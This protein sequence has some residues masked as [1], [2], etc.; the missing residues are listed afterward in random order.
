MPAFLETAALVDATLKNAERR[1]TVLSTIDGLGSRI[2]STFVRC[3]YKR[4]ALNNLIALHSILISSDTMVQVLERIQGISFTP[5]RNRLSSML[6]QLKLAF[7]ES[8]ETLK[9]T[10]QRPTLKEVS[11]EMV[12]LFARFL[13][14][15]IARAWGAF[16]EFVSGE[17]DNIGCAGKI[18][19]PK[20]EDGIWKNSL[21]GLKSAE[22]CN[23]RPFLE[24][25]SMSFERLSALRASTNIS[26]QLKKILQRSN[27]AVRR[28]KSFRTLEDVLSL[29]DAFL[30]VE[31]PIDH[32]VVTSNAKEFVPLCEALRKKL[33]LYPA[34]RDPDV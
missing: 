14:A 1:R 5:M 34:R 4:G 8:E 20:E 19:G 31:A 28:P 23:P 27:D 10:S 24:K 15:K 2:T 11:G 13:S 16:S 30:A 22:L 17:L 9:L 7:A 6:E 25:E 32:T 21:E 29:G 12:K 33:A 26:D 3:E 18:P